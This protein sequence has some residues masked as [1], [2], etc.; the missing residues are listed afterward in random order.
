MCQQWGWS[1]ASLLQTRDYHSDIKHIHMHRGRDACLLQMKY[2]LSV[3]NIHIAHIMLVSCLL[4]TLPHKTHQ[5][6][7]HVVCCFSCYHQTS[8][9]IVSYIWWLLIVS[10]W[11]MLHGN[12]WNIS[13]ITVLMVNVS[14]E[15]GCNRII[16]EI[17]CLPTEMI[18][19]FLLV[20]S[21]LTQIWRVFSHI[22]LHYENVNCKVSVLHMHWQENM[23]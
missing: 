14:T 13:F 6:S 9:S 10:S 12:K 2:L 11:Q 20:G 5:G 18:A 3:Y 19:D 8:L 23:F 22:L 1:K 15:L 21:N 7:H 17:I 4:V 16:G